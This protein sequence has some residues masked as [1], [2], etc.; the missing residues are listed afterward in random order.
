[1]II[2]HNI[3]L[4]TSWDSENLE[5][6]FNYFFFGFPFRFLFTVSFFFHHLQSA[7]TIIYCIRMNKYIIGLHIDVVMNH[8]HHEPIG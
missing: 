4:N 7:P 6:L 1:M 2:N 8:H 3:L 5:N